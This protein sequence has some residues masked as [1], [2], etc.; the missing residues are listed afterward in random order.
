MKNFISKE[1]AE[2]FVAGDSCDE[3]L[4]GNFAI[5]V[6]VHFFKS[7]SYYLLVGKVFDV[8]LDQ[9]IKSKQPQIS[10]LKLKQARI[11]YAGDGRWGKLWRE[12]SSG[13][14]SSAGNV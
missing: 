1:L 6:S 14:F 7:L 11:T 9:S 2:L 13:E 4:A 12:I 3:F 5:F 8:I 10:T